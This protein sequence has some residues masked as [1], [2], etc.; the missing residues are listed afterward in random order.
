[1]LFELVIK[2]HV[3]RASFPLEDDL[4][5]GSYRHASQAYN[6]IVPKVF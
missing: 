6:E 5:I 3:F 2:H 4:D 1:M